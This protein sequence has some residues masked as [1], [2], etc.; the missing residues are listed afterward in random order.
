MGLNTRSKFYY[1]FEVTEANQSINFNEGTGERLAELDIGKYTTT[2]FQNM[3]ATRL[4]EIGD[5]E[6]SVL[7]DRETRIVTISADGNFDLL[8]TT[9][10]QNT[11]SAHPIL[12]YSG[13]DLTGDDSYEGT[14]AIGFEYLPQFYLQAFTPFGQFKEF[15][16]GRVN[17]SASGIVETVSFGSVEFMECNVRFITN[18]DQGISN[19]IETDAQGYENAIAFMDW[20]YNKGDLEFMP[21]RDNVDNYFECVLDRT[22]E[23][24]DGISFRLKELF[25]QRFVGYYE[26]GNL[27]FRRI[28]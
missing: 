21:D 22:P 3:I 1:G 10:A 13:A 12:G 6:Y 15:V 5:L 28:V 17:V 23:S 4:N 8:F 16:S 9:G 24:S 7:I 2:S 27:R 25:S 18:I 26:T 11:T 14:S 19:E 20:C